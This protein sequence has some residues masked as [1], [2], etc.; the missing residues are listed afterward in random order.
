MT[1][2]DWYYKMIPSHTPVFAFGT[3]HLWNVESAN[4]CRHACVGYCNC[5]P[6]LVAPP[7]LER[8]HSYIYASHSSG[9]TYC[10]RQLTPNL[11]L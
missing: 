11:E 6:V 1:L 5:W 10:D 7:P 4:L 3:E 9:D 2:I 8:Y